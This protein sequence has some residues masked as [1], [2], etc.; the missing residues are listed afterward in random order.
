MQNNKIIVAILLFSILLPRLSFSQ[1]KNIDQIVAIVGSNVILKSDIESQHLQNQ[2][3][4]LTSAGDM[5]CEILENLLV[6]RL[7][8]A[9][10]ELDTNIIVTDN[11]INQNIEARIQYFI[12]NLGSETAVE[13]YFKKPLGVIR[14]EL[15][16]VVR[17]ENLSSQMRAKII[18]NIKVTPSE[19][20]YFYRNLSD[21]DKPMINTR[22][23]YAQISL[24]PQIEESEIERIKEQLRDMKKRIE[25]GENFATFAV[26]YSDCPSARQGGDLG[27]FGRATMDP[28]FS[29]VAFN[30]KPG[31]VSNVVR[32]EFGFHIIQMIDKR[33]DR[34]HA[35]H[36]LMKPKVEPEKIEEASNVLDSLANSI[37]KAE[38][39]FEDAAMRYSMDV[40]SRNNGG[41]VIN[42]ETMSSKFEPSNLSPEVAKIITDMNINEISKPFK[43]IDDKQREIITIVKLLGKTEA[44]RANLQD[45]YE[46]LS[47][48]Y[49]QK[50]Q[51]DAI[52]NWISERQSKTYIRIDETYQNC[53]FKFENWMK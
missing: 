4:G 47:E 39:N 43:M 50:K 9:E 6:E 13:E 51:N 35:R 26:L 17:N 42:P 52:Q 24:F 5:K 16:D 53:D 34:I 21:E 14:S 49:L 10:A 37:R 7:M 11:Q 48:M 3:Q 38:I 32:S 12:Q 41:R 29:A 15:K 31:Q 1:D 2:A 45:D 18:E 8:V 28:A 44:H 19:V 27:Y 23:E 33:G 36:I 20:R 46:E 22:Y 30:L 40:N 25:D